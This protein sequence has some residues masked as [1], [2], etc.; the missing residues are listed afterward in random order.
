[1]TVPNV[2]GVAV[3]RARPPA[4][5]SHHDRDRPAGAHDRP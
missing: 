3:D 2:A 1:M 5:V 4:A